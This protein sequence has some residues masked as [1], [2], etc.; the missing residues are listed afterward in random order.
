M[1]QS[2]TGGE[3]GDSVDYKLRVPCTISPHFTPPCPANSTYQTLTTEIYQ[4]QD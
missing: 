3:G 4:P 1:G 2:V